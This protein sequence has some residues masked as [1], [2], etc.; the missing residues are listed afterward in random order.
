MSGLAL[1]SATPFAQIQN[2]CEQLTPAGEEQYSA[3]IEKM[4]ELASITSKAIMDLFGGV[5]G[6]C[7]L[8]ELP[9][10]ECKM[11]GTGYLD[12]FQGK[13]LCAPVMRGFDSAKRPFVTFGVQRFLADKDTH[14][15]QETSGGD[16]AFTLFQRYQDSGDVWM[17][18]GH[19]SGGMSP[20]RTAKQQYLDMAGNKYG[21]LNELEQLLKD[22]FIPANVGSSE[23][24]TQVEL[25]LKNSFSQVIP[26][27]D[28]KDEL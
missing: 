1:G 7:K 15:R 11:G 22:G 4:T 3:C 24:Q 2:T 16:H 27:C 5:E 9:F 25:H 21:S 8:P 6:F 13:D 12:R 26:M 14:E 17:S 10:E 23:Q 18:A 28:P 20:L 19:P